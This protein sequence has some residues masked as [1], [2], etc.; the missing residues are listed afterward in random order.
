[1]LGGALLLTACV[2]HRPYAPANAPQRLADDCRAPYP[3]EAR[4]RE[5]E[6][7]VVLRITIDAQGIVRDVAVISGPGF[8]LNETAREAVKCF[9]FEPHVKDGA[10]VDFTFTY[11]YRFLLD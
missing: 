9:K 4:N 8:G 7:D 1:M 5:I 3:L 11:T 2:A 10:P 6:G